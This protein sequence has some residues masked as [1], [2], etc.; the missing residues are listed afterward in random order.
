MVYDA[1]KK[2]LRSNGGEIPTIEIKNKFDENLFKSF[3]ALEKSK[4]WIPCQDFVAKVNPFIVNNWLERM[5]VH[6][7]EDKSNLILADLER[8]K[9]NWEEVF[10]V[11]LAKN[12]GFK[13]NAL[14]FELLAKS[15]P[16]KF[17]RANRKETFLIEAC[18][19]GQS[20]FLDDFF[21]DAYPNDLIKEYSHLQKK[22]DLLPLQKYLWKFS[23]MRPN[24]FPTI[25]ISQFA[26]LMSKEKDL[27]NTLISE[28][29]VKK[30]RKIFDIEASAYWSGHFTFDKKVKCDKPKRIGEKSIDNLIIN[31]I[32]PFLFVYGIKKGNDEFKERALDLLQNVDV[33]KNSIVDKMKGLGMRAESAFDSQALLQL[34]KAYCSEKKCLD[35]AIGNQIINH[36]DHD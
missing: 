12:F 16:H 9:N 25:R 2:I 11:H 7:M 33:E 32:A 17:I 26:N 15:V 22:Y 27:F 29:S 3:Q 28:A 13:V 35:C 30:I 31:T 5:L 36:M 21:T 10:Y 4:K 24:N 34:K 19:F 6:R 14:P 18:L 1:D 20:G 8:T 23:R